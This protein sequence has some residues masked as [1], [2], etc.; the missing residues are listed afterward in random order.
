[1]EY[2]NHLS[3]NLNRTKVKVDPENVKL[4]NNACLF[5]RG[6]KKYI[7]IKYQMPQ[8][9]FFSYH[10]Y[11][12]IKYILPL[13]LLIFFSIQVKLIGIVYGIISSSP[14]CAGTMSME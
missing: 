6:L 13:L 14:G 11:Y 2:E 4:I 5:P 9:D 3:F 7:D 8:Q 10:Y 12:Y 1:M